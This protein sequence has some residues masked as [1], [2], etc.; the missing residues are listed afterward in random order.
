MKVSIVKA[1]G[2]NPEEVAKLTKAASLL[3]TVFNSIAFRQ[4]VLKHGF[5][6]KEHWWS[7]KRWTY[8]F[9]MSRG[10]S[11]SGVLEAVLAG[12]EVLSPEVDNEADI[13]LTI[14]RR[15]G[16]DVIGYTYS[17]TPMQWIYSSFFGRATLADIASNL[18]HEYCHKLGFDHEFNRTA[19]RQYTVPYGIGYIVKRLAAAYGKA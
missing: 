1:I 16:S 17:S 9:R 6:T 5:Y 3:E 14:D 12:C 7:S 18:A 13:Q 10:K 8:S 2:F 4:E 15:D 11:N 19:D